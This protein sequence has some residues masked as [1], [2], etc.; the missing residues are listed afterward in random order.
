MKS[1]NRKEYKV[2]HKGLKDC[3]L[4]VFDFVCFAPSLCSLRLFF[5]GFKNYHSN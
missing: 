1:I 5:F 3:N 2:L 4:L